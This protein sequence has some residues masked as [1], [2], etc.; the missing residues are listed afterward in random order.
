LA[1]GSPIAITESAARRAHEQPKAN[2]PPRVIDA[3]VPSAL[4]DEVFDVP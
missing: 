3:S 2:T 1:A 4:G